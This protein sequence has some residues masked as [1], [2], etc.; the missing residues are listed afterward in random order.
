M[1]S[2][3][4]DGMMPTSCDDIGGAKDTTNDSIANN[5]IIKIQNEEGNM[6]YIKIKSN[7]CYE[8][9]ISGFDVLEAR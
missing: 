2:V 4:V 7:I 8:K 5:A 3:V 1:Q 9:P 6:M